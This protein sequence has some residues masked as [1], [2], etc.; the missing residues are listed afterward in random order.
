[1]KALKGFSVGIIVF[2]IGAWLLFK[3]VTVYVPIGEVGVRTQE[4]ALFGSKGVVQMD[5]G[6]GWHRDLGPI[7]SWVLFDNTVQTLEMT[8]RPDRGSM[9][10][11]DD[12]QVQSADGYAVSVDVTVKY[13]IMKEN[14]HNLYED[15]GS[16][17]KYKKI[18]RNEAQ[19]ACI[20]LFGKMKT[21]DF[22]IPVE[23][24]QKAEEVKQLLVKSLDD[25]FVEVI[26]VLIRDVQ[27]D[28][29][30][31]NKIRKKKLADQEVELNK[32]M[33]NAAEMKGKTELIEAETSKLVRIITKEKEAAL[34]RMQAE[35]DREIT[36]IK[37]EYERYATEKQADADLIAAQSDAEGT[38]LMKKAEA[39]GERM[40][41]KAM[42]GVGGSTIV[43]LEAAKN[44]NLSEVT[45][46]T[47]NTDLLDLEKMVTKL[48]AG[49]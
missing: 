36:K 23:R 16:G 17:T 7:D 29:E 5:F 43:A 21:E 1:M 4:Y 39:E 40:R 20:A 11:R 30:Y 18:V 28:P 24:R 33:A 46:S 32:S 2:F 22:Y 3:F 26:D 15:T 6:P 38:L 34:I 8:K 41:N 37:A 9:R 47:I 49:R 35:T 13:R 14:A 42:R 44:L 19:K 48:G 10:G 45:I 12:V 27:F 25:N 31:E